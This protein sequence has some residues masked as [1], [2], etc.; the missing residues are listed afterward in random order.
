[1]RD[2]EV[3]LAIDFDGTVSPVDITDA[4]I[5]KFASAGWEDAESLWEYGL[6]GS[7]ECLQQQISLIDAPLM[8]LLKYVD[9]FSI[10]KHF[11]AFVNYL[12]ADNI[13]FAIISDGFRVFAER[14][15]RNAGLENLPVYANELIES[16]G[17]LK[18]SFPNASGHCL[19][20][21]CKCAVAENLGEG[22]PIILIG[23]G[24]SDFGLAEKAVHVISKGSLSMYCEERGVVYTPFDG[25]MG[26][27]TRLS[28]AL[29][30]IPQH[31]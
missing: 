15:L 19:S 6:I 4:V 28:A 3:F 30:L 5:K 25:F 2:S 12:R 23:D 13:P 26:M 11:S 21:T 8:E 20:G 14:L 17:K 10:D 22:L 27:E 18:I 7:R 9:S 29:D 16:N 31:A 1:M 24:R